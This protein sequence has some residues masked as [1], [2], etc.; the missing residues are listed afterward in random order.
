MV[1]GAVYLLWMFQR[2]VL[3]EPSAF[4]LGLKH[5]LSDMTATE[6]LT[7]APLGLLVVVFGL[8]PGVLLDLIS[9]SA[10]D[11]LAA[12]APGTAIAIDPLFVAAALGFVV[13]IVVV[14]LLAL[15]PRPTEPDGSA[16]QVSEHAA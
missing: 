14:R 5:H 11:A 12:V 3:G 10:K 2:V 9:G 1:L 8:F 15:R 6:I 16:V 4:L 13:V 7:L